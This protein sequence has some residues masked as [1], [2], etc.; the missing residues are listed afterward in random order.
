MYELIPMLKTSNSLIVYFDF[1]AISYA[2]IM[3]NQKQ[4]DHSWLEGWSDFLSFPKNSELFTC[5]S[6]YVTKTGWNTCFLG[7][8]IERKLLFYSCM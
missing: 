5:Q 4:G 7:L 6:V 1:T 3:I 8:E 2:L